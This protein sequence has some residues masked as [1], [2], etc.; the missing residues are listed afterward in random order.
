MHVQVPDKNPRPGGWRS[1][2]T[3]WSSSLNI[4]DDDDVNDDDFDVDVNDD[5]DD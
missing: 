1:G 4:V 3:W 2:I 5:E